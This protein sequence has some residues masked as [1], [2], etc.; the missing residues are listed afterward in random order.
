MKDD[1]CMGLYGLVIEIDWV[2]IIG[3][4]YVHRLEKL[5]L[6]SRKYPSNLKLFRNY[7]NSRTFKLLTEYQSG[8]IFLRN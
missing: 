5:L 8:Y 7:Q 2:C 4:T 6:N 3:L 1:V